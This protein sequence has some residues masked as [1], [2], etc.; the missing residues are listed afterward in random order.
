MKLFVDDVRVPQEVYFDG[1]NWAVAR[2]Y[3]EAI[4]CLKSGNVTVLSLDHNLAG[5]KTG[6]DILCWMEENNV[7]PKE[8]C[9]VH[10]KDPA[11]AARMLMVINRYSDLR[12]QQGGRRDAIITKT[13][14]SINRY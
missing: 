4:D 9:L 10:S 13:P 3:E 7:W 1:G 2:T 6:Y 11:G 12:G 5:L 8:V 14:G